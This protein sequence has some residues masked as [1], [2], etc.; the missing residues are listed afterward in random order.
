[1]EKRGVNF[2][3]PIWHLI[4]RRTNGIG[5]DTD[6]V[7]VFYT[8]YINDFKQQLQQNE[9]SIKEAANARLTPG[10]FLLF[11]FQIWFPC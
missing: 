11:Y 1:M 7:R 9:T 2:L 10:F 5:L 6:D 4:E 8:T 3:Y